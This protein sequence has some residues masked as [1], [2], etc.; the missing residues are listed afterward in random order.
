[1]DSGFSNTIAPTSKYFTATSPSDETLLASK[2]SKI[3]VKSQGTLCLK[4]TLGELTISIAMV[5]PSVSSII[6]FLS[7]NLHDGS[8]LKG[9][10]G[11]SNLYNENGMLILTTIVTKNLLLIDIPSPDIALSEI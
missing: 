3:Q 8:N 6:V 1:M 9:L 11:G 4:T 2:R 10:K 7:P 5:L